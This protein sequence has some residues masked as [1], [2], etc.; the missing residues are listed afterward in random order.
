MTSALI[1]LQFQSARNRLLTRVKRLKKPKYL[2][3]L[4]VGGLYFYFYF[5][6]F[7]FRGGKRSAE[8]ASALSSPEALFGLELLGA[9]VLFIL[10]VAAWIFPRERAALTFT[11]AEVAFLFPAPISRRALIHFKLLRSQ[12]RILFTT[13]LMTL[14]TNRFGQS[15]NGWIHL[16]GW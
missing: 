7:L 11:E 16:A 3:G 8:V 4:I 5:F 14:L 6:R 1:Y 12:L 13:V 9:V 15:S 10:V 2:V